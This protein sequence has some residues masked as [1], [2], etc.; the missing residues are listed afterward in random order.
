L[1]NLHGIAGET[2]RKQYRGERLELEILQ[3][4]QT[5]FAVFFESPDPVSAGL[6]VDEFVKRVARRYARPTNDQL[7]ARLMIAAAFQ[8]AFTR[9]EDTLGTENA[10]RINDWFQQV[11]CLL[12]DLH[13][14][15]DPETR[16]E[17]LRLLRSTPPSQGG[18]RLACEWLFDESCWFHL[19]A[20]I[21]ALAES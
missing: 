20:E 2:Y 9:I 1:E 6:P 12:M 4:K 3:F 18:M 5:P 21:A 10:L 14:R 15:A 19:P 8:R 17:V 16:E 7:K 11:Y 13:N